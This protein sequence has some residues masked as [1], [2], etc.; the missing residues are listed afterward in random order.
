MCDLEGLSHK[1]FSFIKLETIIGQFVIFTLN[2]PSF[3]SVVSAKSAFIQTN[4]K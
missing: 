4:S 2:L 1:F 3:M